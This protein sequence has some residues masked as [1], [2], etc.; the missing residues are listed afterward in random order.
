MNFLQ[1]LFAGKEISELQS[2]LAENRKDHAARLLE[3]DVLK[4]S[5]KTLK[6]E[7][8]A[9]SDSVTG[10]TKMNSG[11]L[12]EVAEK[13]HEIEQLKIRISPDA[14][15]ESMDLGLQVKQTE[16]CK[17]RGRKLKRRKSSQKSQGL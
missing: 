15:L 12:K 14:I 6:E 8:D 3:C 4:N 13:D 10:L 9:L 16:K 17:S 2:K 7:R 1:K 11:L 5:A